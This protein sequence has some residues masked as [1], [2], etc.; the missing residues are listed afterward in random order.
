[1]EGPEDSPYRVHHPL[2]FL[3]F[4]LSFVYF[5]VP[6]RKSRTN[7][8]YQPGRHIHREPSTP[9]RISLQTTHRLLCHQN[10]PPQRLQWRER[11]YVP[12]HAEVRRMEAIIAHWRSAR[13]CETIAC[14]TDA[15]RCRGGTHRGTVSERSKEI[16]RS[17]EGLD[18]EVCQGGE[19]IS[20]YPPFSIDLRYGT[21][22][23]GILLYF[24]LIR[25]SPLSCVPHMTVYGSK[26]Q[27]KGNIWNHFHG[28]WIW[29]FILFFSGFILTGHNVDWWTK[30]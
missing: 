16:W 28:V 18:E 19:V 17:C 5:H 20:F 23:W 29:Y 30:W 27:R 7:S 13:I 8:E 15:R 9:K 2:L 14:W 6:S 22:T 12:W 21:G 10:I 4:F 11:I 26:M 25:I 3:C 1:M 24:I